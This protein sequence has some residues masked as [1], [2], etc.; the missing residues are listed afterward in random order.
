MSIKQAA[1]MI[2]ENQTKRMERGL[3]ALSDMSKNLFGK[4]ERKSVE[5]A[6]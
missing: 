5:V 3:L 4:I 2:I 6:A 1:C